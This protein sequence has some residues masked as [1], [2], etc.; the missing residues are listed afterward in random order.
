MDGKKNFKY[1]LM[2]K[3]Q[4]NFSL[5]VKELELAPDDFNN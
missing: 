4:I 1:L 2:W 5:Y 3:F